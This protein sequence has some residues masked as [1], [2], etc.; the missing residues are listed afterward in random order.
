[1]T[2]RRVIE[3]E[4]TAEEIAVIHD[5]ARTLALPEN[6]WRHLPGLGPILSSVVIA[7]RTARAQREYGLSERAAVAYG[8]APLAVRPA[9]YARR[10][11]R[12]MKKSW[13]DTLSAS[14]L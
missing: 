6:D 13:A 14:H 5:W 12:W 9:S 1:M 11:K 2:L 10:L 4:L 3:R 8:C 7:R